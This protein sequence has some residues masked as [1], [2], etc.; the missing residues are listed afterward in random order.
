MSDGPFH[1]ALVR[2][3]MMVEA[4]LVAIAAWR[5]LFDPTVSPWPVALSALA[6][7]CWAEARR[8]R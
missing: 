5:S 1:A 2:V 6:V 7:L 4:V 8:P 3:L